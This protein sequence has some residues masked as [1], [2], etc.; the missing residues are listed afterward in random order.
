MDISVL[1]GKKKLSKIDLSETQIS[2]ISLLL[3][4]PKLRTLVLENMPNLDKSSLA[5][6]KEAG[7]R[8]RGAK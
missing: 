8:I 2:D 1:V 7:V 3:G 6:L 5:A 4:V